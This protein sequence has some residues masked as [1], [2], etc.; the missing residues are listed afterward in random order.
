MKKMTAEEIDTKV[1]HL[2]AAYGS[3]SGVLFGLEPGRRDVVTSI[4]KAF[5]RSEGRW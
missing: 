4:L 5:L 3:G 2:Y 1:D